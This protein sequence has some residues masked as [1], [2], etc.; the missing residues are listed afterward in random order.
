MINL[1]R[2][3]NNSAHAHL[4]SVVVP[5][6]VVDPVGSIVES[7]NSS[8]Y[9]HC[10]MT[11]VMEYQFRVDFCLRVTRLKGTYDV[12]LKFIYSEKATK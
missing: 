4:D 7:A 5:E 11:S 3:V 6:G 2:V 8:Q 10:S 1:K 9:I 12:F